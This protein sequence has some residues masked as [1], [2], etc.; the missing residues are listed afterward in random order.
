MEEQHK[1]AKD[2]LIAQG[3][4]A[5]YWAVNQSLDV[6]AASNPAEKDLLSMLESVRSGRRHDRL[7][8]SMIH[9]SLQNRKLADA[10]D[11][12]V[13]VDKPQSR[14]PSDFRHL[15]LSTLSPRVERSRLMTPSDVRAKN[16][17]QA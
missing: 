15:M 14:G 10:I 9:Q 5:Q 4:P 8:K 16:K 17:R 12:D 2:S 11:S 1:K 13:R 3:G 6:A 7:A